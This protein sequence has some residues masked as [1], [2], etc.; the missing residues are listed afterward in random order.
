MR[1][2][3]PAEGIEFHPRGAASAQT[4]PALDTLLALS[5]VVNTSSDIALV[6]Q[7]ALTFVL[8]AFHFPAGTLR[9]LDPQTG[10]LRLTA[11]AGLSPE[12]QQQLSRTIR[13]GDPPCGLVAKQR[14]IV[15]FSDLAAQGQG[16]AAWGRAG[17]RS[18]VSAPLESRGM[19][20]GVLTMAD[21]EPRAFDAPERERLTMLTGLIGMAV[22]NAELF[23]AA[24]RKIQSLSALTRYSQ[25]LGPTPDLEHVVRISTERMTQLL[26]LQRTALLFRQGKDR[27]VGG[28]ACGFP[29]GAVQALDLPLAMLPGAAAILE[30]GQ[31]SIVEDAAGEGVLPSTFTVEHGVGPLLAVPLGSGQEAIGMLLGCQDGV[32][33]RLTADEL[34]MAMIFANKASVWISGARSFVKEQEARRAAEAAEANFRHLLEV[35]PDAILL[36]D[37]EGTIRL[38]NTQ[39]ERMFGYER[40]ELVGQPV[41]ILLPERFRAA[42]HHH[43]DR[44]HAEPRTRPMGS[45][46]D[47]YARRRDGTEFPV[48]ISLSPTRADFGGS[49]ISVIRDVTS[50]REAALER[51]RLLASEQQKGEQLKLAVREAHHRIKNNLQAISDL[52]Y[53]EMTSEGEADPSDILRESVE[54]IQSIALVHDLLT[55]DEDVQTVDMNALARRL[56]PMV[57]R[58]GA[59]EKVKLELKVAP[60]PLSSKMATNLALILNELA[61]NASK[62]AFAGREGG[63]FSVVLEPANG[64]LLLQVTD[65]GP[66]LPAGFSISRNANVGL[67]VVR[68][69]AER[70]LAGKLSFTSGSGESGPGVTVQIWFPW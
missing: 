10:A 65:D 41:E 34:E 38:V 25:D 51:E 56:V 30:E 58:G 16:G 37:T 5:A 2:V 52:L 36:V 61:S 69:L 13:L 4:E 54:R 32:S 64:G 26:P 33:L 20:L 35:A 31:I 47:L 22:A 7:P 48:E 18:V 8:G 24:Q 63:R 27:I 50:R 66:G 68:T 17:Y 67:Q 21:Q 28:G 3:K 46:L 6:L 44:F 39:T 42:H 9:L 11:H 19:L 1:A 60:V 55:Q 45:G 14:G 49:V 59:G 53:L 43:R 15:A 62:H 70:D 40:A 57:V 29:P 12:L 23:A